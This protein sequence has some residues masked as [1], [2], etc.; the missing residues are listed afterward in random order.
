MYRY[1]KYVDSWDQK[2]DHKNIYLIVFKKSF[3]IKVYVFY[4]VFLLGIIKWPGL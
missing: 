3:L 2:H 4:I 1:K